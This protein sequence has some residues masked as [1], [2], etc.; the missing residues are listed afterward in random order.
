MVLAF[1]NL[2]INDIAYI[3][4]F[5]IYSRSM[6]V[7]VLGGFGVLRYIAMRLCC[8]DRIVLGAFYLSRYY[9]RL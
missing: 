7:A 6:F 3:L 8:C 1:V 5:Y 4:S 2:P 9:N